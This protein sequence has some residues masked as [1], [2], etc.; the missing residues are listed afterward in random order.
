MSKLEKRLKDEGYHVLNFGYPSTSKKIEVLA[1]EEIPKA[2]KTCREHGADLIHFV[3]HSMGGI[4][5]RYYLD[6]H[7]IQELGRVVMLSPP[8]GG[9]IIVDKFGRVFLFRWINGPA[10]EQ[11]GTDQDSIPR[12]L[13]RVDFDLGVIAGDRSIN[14]LFSAI[15]PGED[16]GTI[17]VETT[18]VEGM[19]DFVI[20][21]ATHTYIMKNGEAIERAVD[22]LKTGRF[23]G[24]SE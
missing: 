12:K 1:E 17:S 5:V 8:N 14:H 23:E 6:Q 10:G 16:D 24:N 11:L 18:R 22:Y 2:L 7:Q 13:G 3:T 4:L 15:I 20:V 19:K 9:S 21:H